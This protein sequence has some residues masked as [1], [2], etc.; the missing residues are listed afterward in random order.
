M[1]MDDY[2][3]VTDR[4]QPSERCRDAVLHA[5][6]HT[7]TH[8]RRMLPV[9]IAAAAMVC[10]GGTIIAA[11]SLGAFDK[12]GFLQNSTAEDGRH[13]EKYDNNNYSGIAE[14]A[15]TV[16]DTESSEASQ[17]F[18]IET[19]SVYC[20]GRTIAIGLT[21]KFADE[22][23]SRNRNGVGFVC[24]MT[25]NGETYSFAQVYTKEWHKD[26]AFY[27]FESC[28]IRDGEENAYSGS[29]VLMLA[30]DAILTEETTADVKISSIRW[31]NGSITTSY[32][33]DV[34]HLSVPIVPQNDLR[35]I[36]DYRQEKN[37]FTAAVYEISP[38]AVIVG[39]G[40]PDALVQEIYNAEMDMYVT[41]DPVV[42]CWYD[43][44][45]NRMES[46]SYYGTPDYGDE[47]DHVIIFPNTGTP[48]MTIEW[49]NTETWKVL[50]R[51]TFV[52]DE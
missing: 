47:N 39:S 17:N 51:L 6:R 44:D 38:N 12:L 18:F 28:M 26:P 49:M 35:T 42:E 52:L 7:I 22:R 15:Q 20:D 43:A 46:L 36:C 25:I 24:E 31:G 2:R 23:L 13:L 45:G 1:N 33:P 16:E 27:Q 21:G 48:A 14:Y 32:F 34:I 40:K 4:M 37:G 9:V 3:A 19:E 11:D 30:D 5:K 10:G 50:E 29:I 8:R 41:H